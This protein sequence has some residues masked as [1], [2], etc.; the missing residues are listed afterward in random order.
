MQLTIKD[1]V[2]LNNGINMPYFGLGTYKIDNPEE[3]MSAVDI[4]LKNEYRLIDTARMYNNERYIGKAISASDIPREEIFITSK[5]WINEHGKD[6]A[7]YAV[8]DSL[9]QL[10][11]DYID[12]YLIHWPNGGKRIEAWKI[13]EALM[14]EG[15]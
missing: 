8:E 4:A 9:K 7:L 10:N 11:T 3:V 2:K 12:M 13:L 5:L 6:K 14:G 15:K 1:T